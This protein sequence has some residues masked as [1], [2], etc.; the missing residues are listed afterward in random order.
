MI[1]NKLKHRHKQNT[2]NIKM[3]QLKKFKI[4]FLNN[5]SQINT[6]LLPCS[7]NEIMLTLLTVSSV[8]IIFSL[9]KGGGGEGCQTDI[10]HTIIHITSPLFLIRRLNRY[11]VKKAIIFRLLNS[12]NLIQLHKQVSYSTFVYLISLQEK[13][14]YV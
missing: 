3:C 9:C 5:Q 4:A 8:T 13:H 1:E 7:C 10:Q 14:V 2:Y 12:C 11:S 6:I